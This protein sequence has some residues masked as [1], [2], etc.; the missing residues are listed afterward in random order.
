M[1]L[2]P[3]P[4]RHRDPK[5]VI[6]LFFGNDNG[7]SDQV[8]T[9]L[10]AMAR[11]APPDL[12]VLV[13]AD[14]SP[15]PGQVLEITTNTRTL[16]K[17][18]GEIDTGNQELI[19]ELLARALISYPNARHVAIGFSGHGSGV[20]DEIEPTAYWRL[21]PWLRPPTPPMPRRFATDK[22]LVATYAL[23][24]DRTP[25]GLLTNAEVRAILRDAFAAAGRPSDRP[26]DLI[27]FDTCLNGMIEVVTEFEDFADCI[28]GSADLQPDTGWDY[29]KWLNGTTASPPGD[30]YAW[31]ALA[32]DAMEA[33]YAGGLERPVTLSAV[34]ARSKITDRF[35]NLVRQVEPFQLRGFRFLEW[36]RSQ[37]QLY[38][39]LRLDSYDLLDF[40]RNLARAREIEEVGVAAEEL[41]AAID[42][43]MVKSIAL[44]LNYANGLAFWFPCARITYLK[45][46][47][48]YR[49]LSFDRLTGWSS[50]LD[51]YR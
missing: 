31:G 43:A 24:I 38:G 17:C 6:I 42:D 50:Y 3:F 8:E 40:A 45:D 23:M 4:V 48:S 33:A 37:S 47:T 15:G 7:L 35:A 28:V 14:T 11:A 25:E 12:A 49:E 10:D 32:V 41:I 20:F 39:G 9:D 30:G 5:F 27:F 44:G 1:T 13:V 34:R 29:R 21:F 51:T 2:Q 36:A 26:V 19:A 18:L 16:L 46:V 22:L